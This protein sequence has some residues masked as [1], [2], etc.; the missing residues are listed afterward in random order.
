MT[1]ATPAVQK[2]NPAKKFW[3]ANKTRILATTTVISLTAVAVLVRAN[4]LHNDFLEEKDLT[5]EY[6]STEDAI[7]QV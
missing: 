3:A 1:D 6:Y 2:P 4:K 7:I 5:D